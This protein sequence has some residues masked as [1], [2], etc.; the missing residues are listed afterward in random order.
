MKHRILRRRTARIA[1][2][3]ALA[4]PLCCLHAQSPSNIGGRTIQLTISSG[5]FPFA[6]SG[7]YRFLP[8]AVDSAYAIVPIAGDVAESAGTHTYT[9]TGPGT[10]M[11]SLED[12]V[13]GELTADCVF[14]TSASGTYTLRSIDLPGAS[15]TGTFAL[16]AGASPTSIAGTTVTVTIT[17]GEFPFGEDGSYRFVSAA[18]GDT[19]N[20]IAVSGDPKLVGVDHSGNRLPALLAAGRLGEKVSVLAEQHAVEGCGAIQQSG[21][22]KGRDHH[23][24]PSTLENA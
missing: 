22:I 19:Y 6:S 13:A 2:A 4:V 7:A 5:S 8:S 3:L 18:S 1:G 20:I 11:L 21:V 23:P 17:S 24:A 9:K 14:D 15:Q 10:A 16:Y 12:S